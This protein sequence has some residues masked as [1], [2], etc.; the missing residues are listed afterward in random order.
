MSSSEPVPYK[1]YKGKV[2]INET[3]LATHQQFAPDR[4]HD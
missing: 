1:G 2:K 3:K 4:K